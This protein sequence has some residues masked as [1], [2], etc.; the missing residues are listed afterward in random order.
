MKYYVLLI[1]VLVT[2]ISTPKYWCGVFEPIIVE[3]GFTKLTDF[4]E[5]DSTKKKTALNF[6]ESARNNFSNKTLSSLQ[7]ALDNIRQALLIEPAKVDYLLLSAKIREELYYAGRLYFD[8]REAAFSELKKVLEIDSNNVEAL[9]NLGRLKT[10]DFL[11]TKNSGVKVGSLNKAMSPLEKNLKYGGRSTLAYDKENEFNNERGN[12]PFLSF[13]EIANNDYVDAEKYLKRVASNDTISEKAFIDISKL[14]IYNNTVSHVLQSW[15]NVDSKKDLS[16][17][18]RLCLAV[19][20]YLNN[21]L[22]LSAKEF[23]TAL[24]LMPADEKENFAVN[25]ARL[26]LKSKYGN[27][28]SLMNQKKIS[29]QIMHFWKVNDPLLLSS[30]NERLLEHYFRVAYTNLFFGN[31]HQKIDGWRTDRGEVFIRYGRPNEV[32]R[33]TQEI[34]DPSSSKPITEV[35]YYPEMIFAFIDPGRNNVFYFAQPWNAI[36]PMNTHE[37]VITLR[38]KN[39]DEYY[40]KFEGPIFDLSYQTYQFAS[41]NKSQ[42]V[43]YLSY[44]IDFTDSLTTKDKFEEGCEV[45]LFMFDGNF[46]K[47]IEN[48]KTITTLNKSSD[49]MVNTLEITLKPL[50]GNLAFEMMR[51]KDKGVT[52]YHGKYIVRD[53][54]GNELNISDLVAASKVEIGEKQ[55]GGFE[56]NNYYVL[57]TAY[58]TFDNDNP[59]FLYYE[60][61][62]LNFGADKL[63]DF[64][65]QLTIKKVGDNTILNDLLDIVGLGS[66]GEKIALTSN[67]KTLERDPQIY[68]QMDMGKYESGDYEIEIKIKD[69]VKEKET[70]SKTLIKWKNE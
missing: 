55:N 13:E 6:F 39:P 22:V 52:A 60:V 16:K 20:Y 27:E 47:K 37:E 1:I 11:G 62:N 29:A 51:K 24:S 58:K 42:T 59:I 3:S 50:S 69:K 25:S 49:K 67:Y 45:G 34:D 18:A 8:E 56:R 33:Y 68:F 43:V 31:P 9:Y 10:E 54:S 7:K 26:L 61:Y 48:K 41:K 53:F 66:R 64:E 12:F 17:D 38:E 28:I 5:S 36:V 14:N 15:E 70:S 32:I 63:T 46:N 4:F 44:E 2:L 19:L 21:E 23:E 65:Q 40:P 35:W 57:P 30:E